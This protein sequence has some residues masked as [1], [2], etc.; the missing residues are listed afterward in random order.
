MSTNFG[1]VFSAIGAA[2]VSKRGEYVRP[3]KYLFEVAAI[4]MFEG[5]NGVTHVAELIVREAQKTDPDKEPSV[6]GSTVSVVNVFAG[7]TAK[8]APGKVKA[9][10]EALFGVEGKLD[11]AKSATL[12]EEACDEKKQPAKGMLIRGETYHFKAKSGTEG[13]GLNWTHVPG[14]SKQDIAARAAAQGS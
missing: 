11:P 10:T 1:K 14:Q 6:V 5:N 13:E 8:V 3:G 9:F 12:A 2:Q 7:A 4:R